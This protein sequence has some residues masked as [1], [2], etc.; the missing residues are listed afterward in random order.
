MSPEQCHCFRIDLQDGF[1]LCNE[2]FSGV[3]DCDIKT[4]G[5]LANNGETGDPLD[6]LLCNTEPE[7][8]RFTIGEDETVI[9]D[10]VA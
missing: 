10:R 2:S 3:V 7:G 8:V 6:R 4:V 1:S 9:S 5:I